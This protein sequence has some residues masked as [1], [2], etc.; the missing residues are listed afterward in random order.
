MSNRILKNLHA[1][2]ITTHE[3]SVLYDILSDSAIRAEILKIADQ[4]ENAANYLRAV[5]ALANEFAEI[6]EA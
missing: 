3:A 4:D 2:T 1:V 6:A 5:E